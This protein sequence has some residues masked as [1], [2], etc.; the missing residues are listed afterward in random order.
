MT[1][2]KKETLNP[3]QDCKDVIVILKK[4]D[5]LLADGNL[6]LEDHK[7]LGQALLHAYTIGLDAGSAIAKNILIDM[8]SKSGDK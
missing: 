5:F 3:F 8:K 7:I 1:T 6:P 2:P 4:L